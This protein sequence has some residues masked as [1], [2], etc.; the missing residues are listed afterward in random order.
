MGQLCNLSGGNVHDKD[1]V[2]SGIVSAR[3]RECNMLTVRMPARIDSFSFAVGQTLYVSTIHTHSIYLRQPSAP[4]YE[5]QVRSGL[6]IYLGFDV[7]RVRVRHTADGATVYISDVDLRISA[8]RR[9][10]NQQV[11]A[12]GREIGG[13]VYGG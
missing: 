10:I 9:G 7:D 4:G 3:P 11:L 5:N 2:V 12:V 6:R 8:A 1:V 13:R